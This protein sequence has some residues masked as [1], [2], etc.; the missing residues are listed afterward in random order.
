MKKEKKKQRHCQELL[1][2]TMG[3]V[4]TLPHHHLALVAP[5]FAP[6]G[7]DASVGVCATGTD[8]VMS[9]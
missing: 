9:G 6:Y 5:A 7:S 8:T 1:D 3:A 4:A 2:I